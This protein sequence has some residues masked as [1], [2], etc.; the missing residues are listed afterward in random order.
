MRTV[1]IGFASLALTCAMPSDFNNFNNV[2]GL[3]DAQD[4]LVPPSVH[5]EDTCSSFCLSIDLIMA[6]TCYKFKECDEQCDQCKTCAEDCSTGCYEEGA[7]QG[8]SCIGCPSCKERIRKYYERG[9]ST[10]LKKAGSCEEEITEEPYC[11]EA[12]DYFGMQ[13]YKIVSNGNEAM[14][15]CFVLNGK[16]RF[17]DKSPSKP[18]ECSEAK[19]CIC[20]PIL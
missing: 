6:K 3:K 2:H 13:E 4:K 12:A 15:G 9:Y 10:E 7:L 19:P 5:S 17:N 1:V 14:P 20:K 16:V 11:K 18:K 8:T